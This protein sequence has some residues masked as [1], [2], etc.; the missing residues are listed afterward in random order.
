[1]S[2]FAKAYVMFN[3]VMTYLFVFDFA[4]ISTRLGNKKTQTRVGDG[5]RGKKLFCIHRCSD[6][7]A[8]GPIGAPNARLRPSICVNPNP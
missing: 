3:L 8:P 1:M 7:Y 5:L 6:V 4:Y 2:H